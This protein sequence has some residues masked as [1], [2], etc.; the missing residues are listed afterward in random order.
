M[1]ESFALLNDTIV[2]P[3]TPAGNAAIAVLRLSGPQA[4]GIVAQMTRRIR[5]ARSH[6]LRRAALYDAAGGLLDD[7]MV[8]EMHGPNSYTGED[9][10]ELHLHGARSVVQASLATCQA[11]GAR[12]A[13]PGEFT[14]RAFLHGRMDLAQAEAVGM[15]VTSQ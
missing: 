12:M 14:L 1:R 3:A 11:L 13:Q 4:R 8:V 2:A 10:V 9:L 6:E 15:L 5:P 7:A